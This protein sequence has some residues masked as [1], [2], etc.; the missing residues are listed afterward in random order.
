MGRIKSGLVTLLASAAMVSGTLADTPKLT[1]TTDKAEYDPGEQGSITYSVNA[2]STGFDVVALTFNQNP[3]PATIMQPL[4]GYD[5]FSSGNDTSGV[6][7]E[8]FLQGLGVSPFNIVTDSQVSISRDTPPF[9]GI[10]DAKGKAITR[11]FTIDPNAQEGSYS[12]SVSE[13]WVTHRLGPANYFDEPVASQDL[14]PANFEVKRPPACVDGQ[15]TFGIP[16]DGDGDGDVDLQD[17]RGFQ[18]YMRGP[19]VDSEGCGDFDGDGDSD[20]G[21]AAAFQRNYTGSF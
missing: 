1:V 17:Y 2:S 3:H 15:G 14:I 8:G 9:T 4:D 10:V 7:L 20:M 12:V 6:Y 18:H 11:Y 16:G 5:I 19:G 21:D 13:A